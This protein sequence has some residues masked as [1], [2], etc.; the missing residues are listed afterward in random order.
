[1]REGAV[2]GRV[3]SHAPGGQRCVEGGYFWRLVGDVVEE[4]TVEK[5]VS[6]SISFVIAKAGNL[7]VGTVSQVIHNHIEFNGPVRFAEAS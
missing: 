1:M 6:T 4:G 5:S 7:L 2:D 3:G